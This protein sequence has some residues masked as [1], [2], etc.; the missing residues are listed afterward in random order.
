MADNYSRNSF[1][2]ASPDRVPLYSRF[3]F[4]AVGEVWTEHSTFTNMFR[5]S[6]PFIEKYARQEKQAGFVNI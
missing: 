3:D 5:E 1:V 4:K 2:I 6:R